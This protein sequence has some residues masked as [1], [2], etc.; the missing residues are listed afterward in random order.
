[1]QEKSV[2]RYILDTAAWNPILIGFPRPMEKL[3]N[4]GDL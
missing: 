3:W 4:G 2:T 1:M